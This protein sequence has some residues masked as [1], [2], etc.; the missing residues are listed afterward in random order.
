MAGALGLPPGQEVALLGAARLLGSKEVGRL[1]QEAFR[2]A[3]TWEPVRHV[4]VAHVSQAMACAPN[5]VVAAILAHHHNRLDGRGYVPESYTGAP[6][7]EAQV[8]GLAEAYVILHGEAS[9]AVL[10]A[11]TLE[12]LR[13]GGWTRGAVESRVVRALFEAL[14]VLSRNPV[15]TGK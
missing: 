8:L 13:E 10:S 3:I 7:L 5:P 1:P 15:V 4:L 14:G 12:A 11:S 9:L 6:P 2:G